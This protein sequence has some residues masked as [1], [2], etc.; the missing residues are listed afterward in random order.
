M[1]LLPCLYC[2]EKRYIICRL[3]RRLFVFSVPKFILHTCCAFG[4]AILLLGSFNFFEYSLII[5]VDGSKLLGTPKKSK[6]KDLDFFI[7]AA[8]LVYHPTQVGISSGRRAALV[9]H[10]A[11]ACIFLRLDDIQHYVLMICNSFGIDDIHG[12]AV[13]LRVAFLYY[14]PRKKHLLSQLLFG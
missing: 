3:I 9:S 8:G 7:Q 14:E 5:I 13:I 11:S 10:H 6:S 4:S 12:F 2:W 1:H